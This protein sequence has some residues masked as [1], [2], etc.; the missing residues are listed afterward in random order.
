MKRD[1]NLKNNQMNLEGVMLSEIRQTEKDQ[2]PMV[3]FL[4]DV[5]GS[6]GVMS[7]KPCNA[8]GEKETQTHWAQGKLA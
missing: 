3:S 5:L 7:N 4:C 2:I 1:G 6:Q 8:E